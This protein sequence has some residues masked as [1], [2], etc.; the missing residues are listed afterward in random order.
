MENCLGWRD[1]GWFA[2]GCKWRAGTQRISLRPW[3]GEKL[4]AEP[5]EHQGG[6]RG[7]GRGGRGEEEEEVLEEKV[8][9][10][11]MESQ[12]NPRVQKRKEKVVNS[13]TV[14]STC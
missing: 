1:Q 11:H 7:G 12:W 3:L 6:G 5:E 13:M 10:E 2:E 14:S 9:A 8:P 4:G